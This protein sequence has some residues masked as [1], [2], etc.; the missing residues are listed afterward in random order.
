M[1]LEY[2]TR[3]PKAA[4]HCDAP[5]TEGLLPLSGEVAIRDNSYHA[6]LGEM[7]GQS[8][9]TLNHRGENVFANG[10]LHHI[11]DPNSSFLLSFKQV[12]AEKL[13]LACGRHTPK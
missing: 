8:A 1:L 13:V 4:F 2:M 12:H 9:F 11:F 10:D 3:L 6:P 5:P 7:W